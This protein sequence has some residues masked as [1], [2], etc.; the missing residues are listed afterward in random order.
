MGV[1]VFPR[2]VRL[3]GDIDIVGSWFLEG[4]D[5]AAQIHCANARPTLNVEMWGKEGSFN[6][7]HT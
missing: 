3:G 2:L 1:G 7:R 4:W 6:G 5:E